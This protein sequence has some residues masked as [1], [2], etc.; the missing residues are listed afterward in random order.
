MEFVLFFSKGGI[1][2]HPQC[3]DWGQV[4]RREKKMPEIGYPVPVGTG[5]TKL[6]PGV[7]TVLAVGL[8][9]I[10]AG[11]ALWFVTDISGQIAWTLALVAFGI[12]ACMAAM[13]VYLDRVRGAEHNKYIE[14]LH[15]IDRME[16][17]K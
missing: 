10:G 7:G 9:A 5:G 2:S 14:N 16:K 17:L 3:S 1:Y 8:V 12:T 15:R 13:G 4:V 6:H 11:L